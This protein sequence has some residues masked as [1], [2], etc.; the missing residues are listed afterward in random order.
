VREREFFASLN[1]WNEERKWAILAEGEK[2]AIV[3]N[4][5]TALGPFS[6]QKKGRLGGYGPESQRRDRIKCRSEACRKSCLLR[7]RKARDA[8]RKDDSFF[9]GGGEGNLGELF[10]RRLPSREGKRERKT[11]LISL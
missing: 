1:P 11:F 8:S 4:R 7:E 6:D 9:P 10:R 3:E 2:D 5:R